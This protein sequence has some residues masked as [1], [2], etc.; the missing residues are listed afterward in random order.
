MSQSVPTN[1][2]S[3][4]GRLYRRSRRSKVL[5]LGA[6]T[7]VLLAS[8]LS[9]CGSSS[10]SSAATKPAGSSS[11]GIAESVA[12]VEAA[13]A[14]ITKWP[15]AGKVSKPTDLHGKSVVLVPI[16]GNV[17]ILHAQVVAETEA[18][19]H[20]GAT[21]NVCDGKADPT[22]VGSCLQEAATQKVFAV[23][24]MGV[25]YKMAPN[26]FQALAAAGTTVLMWGDEAEDGATYP[27]GI[28]FQSTADNLKAIGA[29]QA[30]AALA[31]LDEKA[32]IIVVQGTDNANQLAAGQAA[33]DQ[34]EKQCPSCAK[35]TVVQISS[36]TLDKLASSISA[37]L[38]RTPGANA[39]L[40]L[41]DN[42]VPALLQGVA[43]A[44]KAGQVEIISTGSD[45]AGLQRV[46]SGQQAH[47][48]G[49]PGEYVG[50]VIVNGLM[51]ALAGDTV[52]PTPLVTR[53]F[54]KSNVTGLSLT[55]EAHGSSDWFGDD[56]FKEEFYA[57]WG[58]N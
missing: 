16:L 31:D 36:A 19:E 58:V 33:V 56:S 3:R 14:A 39:I 35:P 32:N 5:G 23:I 2:S 12:N 29:L 47:D 49:S 8:V 45:L 54:V 26:A 43:S 57:S 17:S 42:Y 15:T 55:A 22:A 9:A 1:T 27:K 48:L 51:Q 41:A 6:A 38:V 25:P 37:A 10:D 34:F 53:D 24:T 13:Q 4:R 52:S 21:V 28:H 11:A 40:P 46:A 44:G 7:A 50:Y 20:L 18:L 30:D